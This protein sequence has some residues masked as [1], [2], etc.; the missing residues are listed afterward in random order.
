M[1][2][3]QIKT[4]LDDILHL[5][6]LIGGMNAQRIYK[7]YGPQDAVVEHMLRESLYEKKQ[8]LLEMIVK[9]GE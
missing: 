2:H 7:M 9:D 4:L 3:S 5:A 8:A 6:E 1:T